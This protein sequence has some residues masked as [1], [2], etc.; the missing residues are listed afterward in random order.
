MNEHQVTCF[1]PCRKGSQR[2]PNKNV[3]PFANVSQG[4]VEIKLK[5]LI[6][7]EA[8]GSIVLS[9][10]DEIILDYAAS[11]NERK[12]KLHRRCDALSS[13]TTSTD[14]LVAHALELIP[15]AHILWTHVTSPFITSSHYEEI[16]HKYFK[17]LET[18]HDSLMTTTLIHSFLWQDGEAMNYDRRSEK[19]P[20]T[21][22]LKPIHEVNSGAFLAHSETYKMQ[23][24]RIGKS[25]FLYPMDKL[26][27]H[28]VDWPEDF[29]IAECLLE[30]GLVHL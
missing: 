4:L 29:T 30:K 20:R 9:T 21:Q 22:T 23:N 8:I 1:L 19:W 7:T 16:I 17:N 18:G 25:P 24:D 5:Q 26:V 14:D 3:R 11:L 15:N 2:V 12:I 13:S 28:D 6:A 27:S 10:N